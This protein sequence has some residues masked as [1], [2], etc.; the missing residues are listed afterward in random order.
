MTDAESSDLVR[1][2]GGFGRAPGSTPATRATVSVEELRNPRLPTQA[3]GGYKPPDVEQLLARAADSIARLTQAVDALA[4]ERDEARAE[5]VA[6]DEVVPTMLVNAQ[7]M[8]EAMKVEASRDAATILAEARSEAEQATQLKHEAQLELESAQ[9][10]ATTTLATAQHEARTLV[11]Q[12]QDEAQGLIGEARSEA[13]AVRTAARKEAEQI[14][15]AARSDAD[16]LAASGR[17]HHDRLMA[18][19]THDAQ[20]ARDAL[21]DEM[22]RTDRAIADLRRAWSDRLE[23]ALAQLDAADAALEAWRT[24]SPPPP[25]EAG[26]LTQG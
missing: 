13:D 21:A 14:A 3:L 2:V 19:S 12:A 26:R 24:E 17:A 11:L 7:R 16:A 8:V 20:A 4:K 10:E 9:R 15:A 23:A 5:T 18:E 6:R 1:R 22:Q 25:L